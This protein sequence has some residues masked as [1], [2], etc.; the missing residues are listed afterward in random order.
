ML[1]KLRTLGR[2]RLA[3]V[4]AVALL[5]VALVGGTLFAANERQGPEA[6]LLSHQSV[7]DVTDPAPVA[8][9]PVASSAPERVF[10]QPADDEIQVQ[11][12]PVTKQPPLH[13]NLD[14]N[15]NQLVE[16]TTGSQ[17][18]AS[19][20]GSASAP[21]ADPVLVTFYVEAEH[22]DGVRQY[23]ED[24]GVYVRNV[25]EDYIEAHVPPL[26]LPAASQ[27]PGVLRVDTVI[28]PR[29]AQS[30]SRVISQGV[31]LHGSD[32]WHNAGY[33]GQGVKIGIIDLG[34]EQFSE[35]QQGGEL[36]PNVFARC[37][38]DGPQ[39]PSSRLSDC[40]VDDVHGTAVAETVIDV[41]PNAQLYIA[42]PHSFGDLRNAVDWMAGQGVQVINVSLGY[43]PLGP[44]DGTS[45][46]SNN[47]LRTIDAAVSA[48]ITWV[49]SAGNN[50]RNAWYGALSDPDNDGFHNYTPTAEANRFDLVQGD[51]ITAFLRWD[52]DWGRADCD[53]DL[54]LFWWDPDTRRWV[55]VAADQRVQD[56]TDESFPLARFTVEVTS[57]DGGT[58][59]L[60][61][62]RV[63]CPAE[64]AWVQLITWMDV[65]LEY[66]SPGRHMGNP[67][68]SRNS[69]L[70][71]VGATHYWDTN[72]IA[73]YSSRGPTIDGRT[74]PEISGV[75]CGRSTA[76][77]PISTPR[78]P[79]W[80][81]GTSQASPHVAGLAALVKQRSPDLTPDQLARFL[82]DN[83]QERGT[84]GPDNTWGNGFATL[85]DPSSPV[86]IPRATPITNLAVQAGPGDGEVILSWDAV[87]DATHY[88]IGYVNMEVDYH[89]A[90]ASCTKEWIEAFVYVD[91]NAQNI[92]VSNG[93]AEY[94][95]RRLSPGARHAFTVLTSN[96]FVDTGGGGSVSSEFFWP[97]NPRWTFL[98][99]RN[100]LPSG[101]AVP[102]GECN[103]PT[104]SSVPSPLTPTANIAVQNGNDSGE[105]IISWDAISD[106]TH[107]RIG[108]VNMEFDYHLAKASC[109]GEW[110]EA[111]VYVDVNA[112]NI[113]VSNGRAEY[114]IR[115]LSPGARHAFTVLTSNNF[116][117]TGGGGS[118]SSEFFWPSNPRWTF[119]PGRAGSPVASRCHPS[120]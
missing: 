94:T 109:T 116:V 110:I 114:T 29:P 60:G 86:E 117:D 12:P 48:G 26:L 4:A 16:D 82:M 44:G 43:P 68:E 95:I 63:N 3:V 76:Y 40:E 54:I 80:F 87:S 77:D 59:S 93:R 69:G 45:P 115:R 5:A 38:F 90:K 23:L 74:K 34:F 47:P 15:L 20:D 66:Y 71:A 33:R 96:N 52:D 24:N 18:A 14:A 73:S 30:Q 104:S 7:V 51:E 120:N 113:P 101:I 106:A 57:A 64:P 46:F 85:P 111:F 55:P 83:A 112:R 21:S 56:G 53:L 41:A 17:N 42:Q 25:G 102:T 32:V 61:I 108:Y 99:G 9:L 91:V 119:L 50:A 22:V 81:A 100:T 28:P 49:N 89:L 107:Y 10:S 2:L 8:D 78:G 58:F 65:N 31:G 88:R 92:P 118:V 105:V 98:P 97:S 27:Q 36:P 19:A 6:P 72:T 79:C 70:L 75:A 103:E 39:Q 35:L 37:Y 62:R 67:E 13:P 1:Q 11:L 84:A